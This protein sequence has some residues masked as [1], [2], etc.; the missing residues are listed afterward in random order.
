VMKTLAALEDLHKRTIPPPGMHYVDFPE[1]KDGKFILRAIGAQ[2]FH[3]GN[4]GPAFSLELC[5]GKVVAISGGNGGGKSQRVKLLAA[6]ERLAGGKIELNGIDFDRVDP[7]KARKRIVY[8]PSGGNSLWPIQLMA[9]RRAGLTDKEICDALQDSK[10]TNLQK[11]VS[12]RLMRAHVRLDDTDLKSVDI[13]TGQDQTLGSRLLKYVV[14]Q[15]ML[16]AD[17]FIVDEPYSAQS[18]ANQKLGGRVFRELADMG[19]AVLVVTHE[20]LTIPDCDEYHII[21]PHGKE[22]AAGTPR[23]V[24]DPNGKHNATTPEEIKY[25]RQYRSLVPDEIK[26]ELGL[27]GRRAPA[28]LTLPQPGS[29]RSSFSL[30]RPGEATLVMGAPAERRRFFEGLM[31]VTSGGE[32]KQNGHQVLQWSDIDRTRTLLVDFGDLESVQR[33]F[34]QRRLDSPEAFEHILDVIRMS[35]DQLPSNREAML[36]GGRKSFGQAALRLVGSL[37]NLAEDVRPPLVVVNEAEQSRFRSLPIPPEGTTLFV[38]SNR[39]QYSRMASTLAVVGADAHIAAAGEPDKMWSGEPDYL[40]DERTFEQ[41]HEA[42][43]QASVDG[44]LDLH[45]DM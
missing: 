30:A 29:R 15:N 45:V 38:G 6:L 17:L 7:R 5:S 14:E 3:G 25:L 12:E 8:F 43:M 26:R 2:A 35:D 37:R 10:C 24:F 9:F 13:S 33:Y 21:D 40:R 18:P 32:A 36:N 22:L 19:K 39:T 31:P 28:V 1:R 42:V 41:W 11:D 23:E 20:N 27:F 4:P 34:S 44:G 16:D